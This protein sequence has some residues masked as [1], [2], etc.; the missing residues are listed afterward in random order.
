MIVWSCVIYTY[1]CINSVNGVIN[2][3]QVKIAKGQLKKIWI[4]A[5]WKILDSRGLNKNIL[6]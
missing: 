4:E 6:P 5:I 1:R 3:R 2:G